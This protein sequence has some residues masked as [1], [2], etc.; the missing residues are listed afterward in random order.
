M[1]AALFGLAALACPLEMLAMMGG[2]MWMGRRAGSQQDDRAD[3]AAT[4]TR[5]ATHA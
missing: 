2:M 5:E 1:E 3:T 4:D